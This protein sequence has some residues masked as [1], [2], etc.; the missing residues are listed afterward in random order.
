LYA[1]IYLAMGRLPVFIGGEHTITFG[2]AKNLRSRFAVV[3]FD[4][5]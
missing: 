3:S 1:A 4:A 2:A 5:I